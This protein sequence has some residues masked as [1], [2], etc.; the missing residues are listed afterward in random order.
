MGARAPDPPGNGLAA[1][2]SSAHGSARRSR[3]GAVAIVKAVGSS[4]SVT[5][6]HASGIDTAA[7]CR[8]RGDQGAI[9]VEPLSF[10]R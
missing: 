1:A 3:A 7:P 4:A 2:A 6:R 5:S 9:A 10:L 8:A